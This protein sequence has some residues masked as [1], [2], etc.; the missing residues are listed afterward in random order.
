[1]DRPPLRSTANHHWS[2]IME[3]WLGAFAVRGSRF[4]L[5]LSVFDG[6]EHSHAEEDVSEHAGH[7]LCATCDATP[8]TT[9]GAARITAW[10]TS[11]MEVRLSGAALRA[12]G[13]HAGATGEQQMLNVAA[14]FDR[15][16]GVGR[17]NG[18]VEYGQAH[19][20]RTFRTMLGELQ[21]SRS[22]YRIYY[23]AEQSDRAE[24]AR[25]D[26]FRS[27]PEFRENAVG[28][29]RWLVN[30]LGAAVAIH[31]A[32][33]AIEPIAEFGLARASSIGEVPIDVAALYGSRTMLSGVIAL[34]VSAGTHRRMGR[35]GAMADATGHSGHSG[36]QH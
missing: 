30:T 15:T 29:T 21:L 35:Y 20:D 1:M 22:R 11:W 36:H 32:R 18:L 24:G 2:Q 19:S 13:H 6:A 31:K 4:G 8:S 5:E 34:R 28:T 3:R 27:G 14:S 12:A 23:R 17:I 25:L 7:D 16:V 26:R 9:S 10:P 33:I